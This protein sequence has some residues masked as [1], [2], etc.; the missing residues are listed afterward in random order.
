M[1]PFLDPCRGVPSRSVGSKRLA[2][3]PNLGD[4]ATALV[5]RRMQKRRDARCG[6][7]ACLTKATLV[8]LGDYEFQMK[9]VSRFDMRDPYHLAVALSWPQFLTALLALYLLV[10]VVFA[11]LFWLVPGSGAS[12]R[13]DKPLDNF[14]FSIETLST[15]GYGQMYSTTLYGRLIA[16]AEI[17]CGVAFTAILTGLTFVRFSRPR[18]KMVFCCQSGGSDTQR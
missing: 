10:N 5:V 16:S 9:G 3:H 4:A 8:L 1:G 13:P 6:S 2:I 12:V 15:V 7:N 18:A 11:A 17:A 14:L